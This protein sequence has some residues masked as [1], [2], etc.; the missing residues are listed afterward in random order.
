MRTFVKIRGDQS[1]CIIFVHHHATPLFLCISTTVCM[2]NS[3]KTIPLPTASDFLDSSIMKPM[4]T[5]TKPETSTVIVQ[6]VSEPKRPE[7]AKEKRKRLKIIAISVVVL[8]VVVTAAI[9]VA[10]YVIGK[11]AEENIKT[12]MLAYKDESGK[13]GTQ[14]VTVTSKEEKFE[15]A[16]TG[17]AVFDFDKSLLVYKSENMPKPTCF[18]T[19][20][21]TSTLLSPEKMKG[22]LGD[23]TA[24]DLPSNSTDR[25]EYMN[26][27][28]VVPNKD[29]LSPMSKELCKDSEVIWM[30]PKPDCID[31][32]SMVRSKRA[33]YYYY[34]C[35]LRYCDRYY[36]YYRC[37]YWLY[38]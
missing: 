37:Y 24:S 34:Y 10:V 4:T 32:K 7:E 16:G 19:A 23:N 18:L 35:Y 38:C 6:T 22:F 2:P 28:V 13:T 26:S 1:N 27:G 8:V 9:L 21:N 33:C 14:K 5:E 29:F 20:V 36:C 3:P 11:R 17:T 31:D 12:A 15:I 30:V 25:A